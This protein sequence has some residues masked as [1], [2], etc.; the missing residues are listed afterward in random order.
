[1][2]ISRLSVVA[3][4]CFTSG[5]YLFFF[6]AFLFHL[7]CIFPYNRDSIIYFCIFRDVS[8]SLS[9]NLGN[10]AIILAGCCVVYFWNSPF[11]AFS[12]KNGFGT[13]AFPLQNVTAFVGIMSTACLF[14]PLSEH[15]SGE[16][17]QL[18]EENTN[19][20]AENALFCRSIARE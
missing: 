16:N 6:L 4:E 8:C 10:S 20:K 18:L 12:A 17:E 15:P 13:I 5:S 7:Q 1:M 11:I 14:S 3:L 9:N 2:F 19:L